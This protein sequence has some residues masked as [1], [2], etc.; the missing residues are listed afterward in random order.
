MMKVINVIITVHSEHV[1][2]VKSTCSDVSL[3]WEKFKVSSETK[4]LTVLWQ[5]NISPKSVTLVIA[6]N[7]LE[8][9][10]SF[11]KGTSGLNQQKCS[12]TFLTS[13]VEVHANRNDTAA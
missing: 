5:D 11:F 3:S 10:V 1:N 4:R 2:S 6:D 13:A 7:T 12:I 8:S 9:G